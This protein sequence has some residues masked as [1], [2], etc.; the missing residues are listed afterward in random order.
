MIAPEELS[1]NKN[2][3][4]GETNAAITHKYPTKVEVRIAFSGTPRLLTSSIHRGASR[5]AESTNS[6]QDAV[7]RPELRQDSTATRTTAF[8]IS[9][10]A[11]MPISSS[12]LT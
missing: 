4:S 7:Y 8:M 3:L 10:A 12:A 2:T 6:I 1:K 5:R 9:A 11:G